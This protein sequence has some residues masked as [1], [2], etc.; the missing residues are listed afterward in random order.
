MAYTIIPNSVKIYD[1]QGNTHQ[2]SSLW[3]R[4]QSTKF[5]GVAYLI[6]KGAAAAFTDEGRAELNVLIDYYLENAR[7]IRA[8]LD[9]VNIKYSG[10]VN[11]PYIWFETPNNLSSWEMFHKLLDECQVVGTPGVGFGKCGEGYLRLTAFGNQADVKEAVA[12]YFRDPGAFNKAAHGGV[13][14]GASILP[15][16]GGGTGP[17]GMQPTPE[18]IREEQVKILD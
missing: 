18:Q 3:L 6:Q 14:D 16:Q 7:I 12:G 9:A 4:R 8:G 17:N 11:A 2:L 10:G 5:N 1:E 15:E 13:L